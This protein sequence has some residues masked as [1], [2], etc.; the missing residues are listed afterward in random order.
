MRES[1][2]PIL[3][4]WQRRISEARAQCLLDLGDAIEARRTIKGEPKSLGTRR[5]LGIEF[6]RFTHNMLRCTDITGIVATQMSNILGV[7]LEEF[8]QTESIAKARALQAALHSTPSAIE[9]MLVS[10]Q[11]KTLVT[12]A[13]VDAGQLPKSL[14]P[15][16]PLEG[17]ARCLTAYPCWCRLPLFLDTHQPL[18]FWRSGG[19]PLLQ[20]RRAGCIQAVKFFP[21]PPTIV[22]TGRCGPIRTQKCIALI[23]LGDVAHPLTPS[24]ELWQPTLLDSDAIRILVVDV[25][26]ELRWKVFHLLRGLSLPYLIQVDAPRPSPGTQR[27]DQRA[28]TQAIFTKDVGAAIEREGLRR[29]VANTLSPYQALVCWLDLLA[30]PQSHAPRCVWRFRK[31]C[32][33]SPPCGCAGCQPKVGLGHH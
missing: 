15:G 8:A 26:E 21:P 17:S 12:W 14:L 25:H 23:T 30:G 27:E 29:W 6:L 2:K 13:P 11:Y 33:C 24:I 32:P 18:I 1:P 9:A 28:I 20:V 3:T 19:N 5:E 31:P 10:A 22:L 16:G 4:E 7:K